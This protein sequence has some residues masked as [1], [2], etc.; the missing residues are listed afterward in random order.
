MGRKR[1][2]HDDYRRP[3][4]DQEGNKAKYNDDTDGSI[5]M[6]DPDGDYLGKY[7]ADFKRFIPARD[8]DEYDTAIV[9]GVMFNVLEDESKRELSVDPFVDGFSP[10]PTA[11]FYVTKYD[12]LPNNAK[13]LYGLLY[14][15]MMLSLKNK[16]IDQNGYIHFIFARQTAMNL[17]RLS[18]PKVIELFKELVNHELLYELKSGFS[19]TK[20]LWLLKPVTEE[21]YNEKLKSDYDMAKI[22]DNQ[23][24]MS[25]MEDKIKKSDEALKNKAK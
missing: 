24:A 18:E 11:L 12:K 8:Y 17:L 1:K 4:F 21:Q 13:L 5:A 9:N 6:F 20:T 23:K 16:W 7:T 19:K 3:L 14:S 10:V 25:A 22:F 2:T 15:R